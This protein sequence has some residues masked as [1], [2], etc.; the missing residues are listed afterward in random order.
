M[1]SEVKVD[2]WNFMSAA[3]NIKDLQ[4]HDDLGPYLFLENNN[5]GIF[6]RRVDVLRMINE[7]KC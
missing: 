2:L 6:Q 5:V 1:Q 7:A 3:W 4:I